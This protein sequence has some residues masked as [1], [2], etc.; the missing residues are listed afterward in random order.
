M[1]EREGKEL[2]PK[3]SSVE[4]GEDFLRFMADAEPNSAK[5]QAFAD[6]NEFYELDYKHTDQ[7]GRVQEV[8]DSNDEEGVRLLEESVLRIM[9]TEL[10]LLKH[11]IRKKRSTIP[12]Y[13]VAYD[14]TEKDLTF[15]EDAIDDRSSD[16]YDKV[17]RTL[18]SKLYGS[19][20]E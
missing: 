12:G 4:V 19:P 1:T 3:R 10:A 17:I 18:Q 11:D 20:E 14:R 5:M 9:E 15:L 8:I 13:K 6:R 2:A 7:V 16:I